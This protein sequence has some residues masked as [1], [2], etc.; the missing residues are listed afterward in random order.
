MA[1]AAERA[2]PTYSKDFFE[3]I[4]THMYSFEQ[5]YL[6]LVARLMETYQKPV[7]GVSLLTGVKSK[8]VY[9]VEGA[10]YKPVFYQS[11]E[12]AVKAYARMYEHHRFLEKEKG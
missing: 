11:P 2:D 9:A 4:K 3:K 1:D 8:T 10:A 6:M 5:E 12:R 7:Y